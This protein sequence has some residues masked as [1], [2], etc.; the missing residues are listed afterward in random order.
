MNANASP[1][2]TLRDALGNGP[3]YLFDFLV[4]MFGATLQDPGMT[5]LAIGSI[6]LGL[7]TSA[8]IAV[9]VFFLLYSV[10]RNVNYVANAIGNSGMQISRSLVTERQPPPPFTP[11]VQ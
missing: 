6:C 2:D 3:R 8:L 4:G 11:P 1:L 9:A 10:F 7:A 5:A